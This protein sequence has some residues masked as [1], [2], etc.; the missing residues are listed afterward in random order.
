[1]RAGPA[2]SQPACAG[3]RQ[4]IGGG[5]VQLRAARAGRRV[6]SGRSKAPG[7]RRILT[8][9]NMLRSQANTRGNRRVSTSGGEGSLQTGSA[10]VQDGH[11]S[12]PRYTRPCLAQTLACS[13]RRPRSAAPSSITRPRLTHTPSSRSHVLGSLTRPCL[14]P[15]LAPRGSPA[16]PPLHTPSARSLAC[17]L[18]EAPLPRSRPQLDQSHA[19]SLL[20]WSPP[21]LSAAPASLQRPRLAHTP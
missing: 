10:A 9:M 3:R 19:L 7:H 20:H 17:R 2:G 6:P 13:P 4:G 18:P 21:A 16:A 15:W 12:H 14:A 8:N 1:M 5:A 11:G